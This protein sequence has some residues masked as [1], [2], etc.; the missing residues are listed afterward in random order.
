MDWEA[1][2]LEFQKKEKIQRLGLAAITKISGHGI[3]ALLTKI[4]IVDFG[5]QMKGVEEV[6]KR[7]DTETDFLSH[8]EIYGINASGRH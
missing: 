7:I 8:V 1:V 5:Y 4:K 2:R 3:E 6:F